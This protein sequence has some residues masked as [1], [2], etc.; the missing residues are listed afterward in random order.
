M[1]TEAS[2][3]SGHSPSENTGSLQLPWHAIPRFIPGTTD[4]TEYSGKLEF[5]AAMWPRE[6]MALL[7]P[8]AA[9]LTEGTAFKKVSKLDAAKLKSTDDSGIRLLVSTLGGSWGKTALETKY[10]CF[11]K[12]IYGTLQKSDESND[13]YLARHDVHFEELLSQGIKLEEVRAYILL[14]Q[15][16]LSSEDRKKIVVEMGGTLSYEKVCSAIRLLGSRF[17]ADLQGHRTARTKVYDANYVEEPTPEDSERAFQASVTGHV[18]EAE[19]ELDQEYLDALIAVDDPDATQIQ[20]FEEELETFF[21]DVPA[22]QDALVSYLEA[23]GRLLAKKRSRGFWPIAKGSKSGGKPSKGAGKHKGKGSKEALLQRIAKSHCRNCGQRGHWKAE[24][25]RKINAATKNAEEMLNVEETFATETIMPNDPEVMSS[26]PEEAL[27]LEEAHFAE[28]LTRVQDVRD[29]IRSRIALIP[30]N[31]RRRVALFSRPHRPRSVG[32]TSLTESPA[33]VAKLSIPCPC[34]AHL[35]HSPWSK[36]KIPDRSCESALVQDT[37]LEAIVDTGASRCVMGKQLLNTFLSQ[38]SKPVRG[39]VK[40][41][42]SAVKFRFGNNQT[43]E[44]ELRVLLPIK[45]GMSHVLWLSIEIVPGRTPLLFSKR[46]IKQLGGI[47]D[48]VQDLCHLQRLGKSLRL[49]TGP[50]GLYTLDLAKLCEESHQDASCQHVSEE[51]VPKDSVQVALPQDSPVHAPKSQE[52][53]SSVGKCIDADGFLSPSGCNSYVSKDND[54]EQGCF[55]SVS[56]KPAE[57]T[58]ESPP[59]VTKLPSS[60]PVCVA[61]SLTPSPIDPKSHGPE[62]QLRRFLVP[63]PWHA[64]GATPGS[65]L[66]LHRRTIGIPGHADSSAVPSGFR[67]EDGRKDLRRGPGEQSRMGQVVLRS[68]SGQCQSEASCSADL[69]SQV[70]RTGRGN[71]GRAAKLTFGHRSTRSQDPGQ[72]RQGSAQEQAQ[73]GREAIASFRGR[74]V[75][76]DLSD[77]ARRLSRGGSGERPRWQDESHGTD[78]GAGPRGNSAAACD[79]AAILREVQVCQSELQEALKSSHTSTSS[80][81][82]WDK[83]EVEDHARSLVQRQATATEL[84][85]FLRSVPW[86]L[87]DASPASLTASSPT[88][89]LKEPAYLTFG[90]FRHGGVQ[91]ITRVSKE[92]PWVTQALTR[93]LRL[94]DPQHPFTTVAISCNTSAPPHR[95]VHNLSGTSNLVVPL[96]YPSN[97]GEVWSADKAHPHQ[98]EH[99]VECNR[100]PLVGALNPLKCP[101]YLN[102]RSW[103]CTM[104]WEGNRVILIGFSLKTAERASVSDAEWLRQHGFPESADAPANCVDERPNSELP[105]PLRCELTTASSLLT[106]SDVTSIAQDAA[107]ACAN[108]YAR[109]EDAAWAVYQDSQLSYGVPK[110]KQ[111]DL[112][113][114]YA[115]DNSQ[116]TSWVN[117]LGGKARRFTRTDGDLSSPEGQRRLWDIIQQEQPRHIWMAPEC[118]LWCSWTN[119]HS[120]RSAKFRDEL[121]H[122]RDVDQTHLRLCTKVYQ[123]QCKHGRGFHLEQPSGSSMLSQEN[124]RPIVE[125]TRKV[126][127]HMCAFGLETPVSKRPIKKST[128]ILSTCANLI[129]SL[130]VKQCPGHAEH[131]VVAGKLRELGGASV[132][133]FAGS[134]CQG[135]AKHVAKQMLVKP[136]ETAFASNE[137]PPT[138]RKRF[139]TSVGIPST[140]HHLPAQKRAADPSSLAHERGQPSRRVEPAPL[141]L[142][143]E[144]PFEVWRP[145]FRPAAQSITRNTTSLVSPRSELIGLI[146]QRLPEIQV[147]VLQV[148]VSQSRAILVP[149]TG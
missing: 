114:V 26:V 31:L 73:G 28:G 89:T 19:T 141:P 100:Q 56:A 98:R 65:H 9:L 75:G 92:F 142:H 124:L 82:H 11:E 132:S 39:L 35:R 147:Q 109:A 119:L 79:P 53:G 129:R 102:P 105:S 107:V 7:A 58:D 128:A 74:P 113:E 133:Q 116:L 52:D 14:R 120:A 72:L 97:G 66:D 135:F 18:E 127:V 43:L 149:G 68:S 8:R 71:R 101:M 33:S 121:Q 61:D 80:S 16:Q 5:L 140:Q 136:S 84:K 118:R 94:T 88:D 77:R 111:L 137:A 48:T 96:N 55:N 130:V 1:A 70:C 103:H 50:T 110:G 47:V 42:K 6:H 40:V 148:F 60:Q 3:S 25:P 45:A 20:A 91:G 112:L 125:G 4:V 30:L 13:S 108:A 86:H 81:R 85:R 138:T 95:D 90:S 57:R 123:W 12:A 63:G 126:I 139:K 115:Y 41:A 17:F 24:C 143:V 76:R 22:F 93:V 78:H 59:F 62:P 27:S 2:Q 146:Q 34:P 69:H 87:L 106:S 134:Y 49:S 54:T 32:E 145:V 44:S 131:Q 51:S 46:A 144:L 104:P 99:V 122:Q 83:Q 23:R 10:D 37:V 64:L 36:P 117:R 29:K 67:K 15:S 38:L 21:Q